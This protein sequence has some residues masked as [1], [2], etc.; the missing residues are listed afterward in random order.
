MPKMTQL[1]AMNLEAKKQLNVRNVVKKC[2]RSKV[3]V[4]VQVVAIPI[5]V[6]NFFDRK[7]AM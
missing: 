7:M 6:H 5:A 2:N 4:L 1:L 3:A